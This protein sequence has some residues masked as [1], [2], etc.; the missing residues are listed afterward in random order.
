[1]KFIHLLCGKQNET[2][3]GEEKEYKHCHLINNL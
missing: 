2:Q 1:M 3:T